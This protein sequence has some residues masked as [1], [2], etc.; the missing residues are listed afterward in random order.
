MKGLS[1]VCRCIICFFPYKPCPL[2][3]LIKSLT[4]YIL[5]VRK[6]WLMS[7]GEGQ[8]E[9]GNPAVLV[10]ALVVVLSGLS[11]R[12]PRHLR[13]GLSE[14][15][16]VGAAEVSAIEVEA[17]ALEVAVG[18]SAPVVE[19]LVATEAVLVAT[20]I[21]TIGEDTVIEV[22]LAVIGEVADTVAGSMV[23]VMVVSEVVSGG[24]EMTM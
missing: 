20:A 14:V 17:L 5:W 16:L 11:Q 21:A 4:A 1:P 7:N 18:D 3:P 9:A 12:L 19:A 8:S 2:Q 13:E 15:L 22:D 10:G 6:F 23:V 24:E